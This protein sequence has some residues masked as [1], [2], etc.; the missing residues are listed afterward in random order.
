MGTKFL[1][2]YYGILHPYV[3]VSYFNYN[4]Q[5]LGVMKLSFPKVEFMSKMWI[6][7]CY[8]TMH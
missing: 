4:C 7:A 2:I 1:K 6:I 3:T 8:K 5:K